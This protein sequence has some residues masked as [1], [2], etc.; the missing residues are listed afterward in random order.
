LQLAN[1]CALQPYVEV[2]VYILNNYTT[3]ALNTYFKVILFE[4][5]VFEYD[6]RCTH[7]RNTRTR[8][9]FGRTRTHTRTRRVGTRTRTRTR[10]VSTH[11]RT[12]T[13]G[14]GTRTR[15]RTRESPYLPSSDLFK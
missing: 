5:F 1:F 15:T 3:T 7:T 4:I 14:V 6:F 9:R 13:R 2:Y 12:R 8:V 10:G 11:T